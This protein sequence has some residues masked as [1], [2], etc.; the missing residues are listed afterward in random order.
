MRPTRKMYAPCACDI[1]ALRVRYMRRI[2]P[3][4]ARKKKI[5]ND[6][7]D[8][9]QLPPSNP[10]EP[11][12]AIHISGGDVR[13]ARDLVAGDVNVAGDS[14]SG[15]T[16]SVQRGFS[17]KEVQR[18][19]LIVGGLVF[20]TAA[21]FFL[22]GAVS[23]LTVVNVLQRPLIGGSD[24][25]DAE[26]MARKINTLKGLPPGQ[27]FR[28]AFTEDE[29]SSYVRFLAGPRIGISEGKA[30]LMEET[31][32]LALGGNASQF[33]GLPF[34][35]EVQV[36]TTEQPLQVRR[37]WLKVLPSPAG[38]SFGYI[39]ITPLLQYLNA[40]VTALMAPN[41]QFTQIFQSGGGEGPPPEIGN[42]LLL[43]GFAK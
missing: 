37:A 2:P 43:V 7:V 5:Y 14:I 16:V 35:A 9:P 25:R 13:A 12:S 21:C 4:V 38:S 27:Q 28:V 30:R 22:F 20:A 15:Q 40:Q 8:E 23:A 10:P 42:N 11:K 36:T 39:P 34:A 3:L 24:P 1:C 18:L 29:I 26:A 41:V 6:A 19:V 33:G 31:G 32:L 17:A